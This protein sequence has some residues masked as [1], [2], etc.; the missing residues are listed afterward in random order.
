[1]DGLCADLGASTSPLTSGPE[2]GLVRDDVVGA[3][4]PSGAPA[5][6][7]AAAHVL[8]RR[9]AEVRHP[10]PVDC[11]LPRD[12]ACS[13]CGLWMV[14][15]WLHG[16]DEDDEGADEDEYY[17]GGGGGSSMEV[18]NMM[19]A[20]CIHFHPIFAGCRAGPGLEHPCG[21][22]CCCPCC[23]PSRGPGC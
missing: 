16:N 17:G 15:R 20:A 9:S 21:S 14:C 5:S 23:L 4:S 22:F 12:G 1:M 10:L 6:L 19:M 13:G 8:C 2:D 18:L 11:H 3:A 7:A